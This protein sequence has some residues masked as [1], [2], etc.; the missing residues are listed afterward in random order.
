MS[1]F[2]KFSVSIITLAL[3]LFVCSISL[4]AP[5]SCDKGTKSL[6]QLSDYDDDVDK[7][8]SFAVCYNLKKKELRVLA[9]PVTG[10]II[11]KAN[12]KRLRKKANADART[13]INSKRKAKDYILWGSPYNKKNDDDARVVEYRIYLDGSKEPVKLELV[14]TTLDVAKKPKKTKTLVVK[15]PNLK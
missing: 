13:A 7:T 14:L 8:Y 15:I 6:G 10:T 5:K 2:K 9:Y 12:F 3:V 4:A 11:K 1:I